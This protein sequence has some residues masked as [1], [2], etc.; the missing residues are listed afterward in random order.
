MV[1]L[2]GRSMGALPRLAWSLPRTALSERT[3][4]IDTAPID[5]G[6]PH[7]DLVSAPPAESRKVKTTRCVAQQDELE[8]QQA[9]RCVVEGG[10]AWVP[11]A[12]N[13]YLRHST[14]LVLEETH[15]HG[16]ASAKQQ[17]IGV[18]LDRRYR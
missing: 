17:L 10:R 3:T 16:P 13:I 6:R 8:R 9:A 5:G 1:R 15:G 11:G 12:A 2:S 4:P 18:H 14:T 7:L